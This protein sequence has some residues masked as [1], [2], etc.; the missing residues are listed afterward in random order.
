MDGKINQD[1][2]LRWVTDPTPGILV[3][4]GSD[5]RIVTFEPELWAATAHRLEPG[6]GTAY[7]KLAEAGD[8]AKWWLDV[9]GGGQPGIRRFQ[10]QFPSPEWERP[11]EAIISALDSSRWD[12][13]SLIRQVEGDTGLP[14]VVELDESLTVLCIQGATNEPGLDTLE[15]EAEFNALQAVY[16]GLDLSVRHAILQPIAVRP[17][18]YNLVSILLE[19]PASILWFSGHAKADP[20]GLLLQDGHW[21]T[22]DELAVALQAVVDKGG[23]TP[24]YAV[25]WAC[26]TG[27][28]PRFAVPMAAPPFMVA[29]EKQGIAALLVSQAPLSAVAARDVATKIFEALASGR[30]LDHGV[31]RARGKLLR[32]A[33][34]CVEDTFE[35]ICPVVWS[36]GCPPPFLTWHDGREQIAQHQGIARKILP[37]SLEEVLRQSFDA[38]VEKNTLWTK[39]ARVWVKSATP[40]SAGSRLSWARKLLSLQKVTERTVLW[41]DFSGT[42][43]SLPAHLVL[44]DWLA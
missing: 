33:G 7:R 37:A 3:I 22:P 6:V 14:Q 18:F 36:K 11:W 44:K 40:S 31:A 13:V 5:S 28:T 43:S 27:S 2:V 9:C 10:L 39:S 17:G 24:L 38:E 12:D 4:K 35:W 34:E 23:R 8:F 25:L 21:L 16:E 19:H 41:F 15:L 30:P 29:L 42:T 20:P 1:I 32:D 26:E